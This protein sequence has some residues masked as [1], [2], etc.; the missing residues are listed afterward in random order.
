MRGPIVNTDIRLKT[1]FLDNSKII[2]LQRRK[3]ADAILSLL[4]FW[5]YVAENKPSGELCGMDS[6]DIDIA[7]GNHAT[8]MHDA[9]LELGFIEKT[10]NGYRVHDWKENQPWAANSETRSK[11]AS[12]AAAERWK[13]QR[14]P[15][16]RIDA[17][18]ML[19]AYEP[20]AEGNAPFLSF[21]P[22]SLPDQLTTSSGYISLV[23]SKI[24]SEAWVAWE[25]HRKEKKQKLT[26]STAEAQ[27]KKFSKLR[28]EIA[29]QMILQSI[30]MGWTGLF[31]LK[32]KGNQA[33]Q[34]QQEFTP[35]YFRP[36][37]DPRKPL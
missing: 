18:R 20:H 16:V 22:L 1:G 8:G 3:G 6:E 24:F 32:G 5:F 35:S 9:L 15:T 37:P 21:P 11:A 14:K 28:P 27:L 17:P 30:D 10:K 12:K 7:C 34:Q 26:P 29:A 23:T 13:P 31:E 33:P 4:R 19:C 36:A 2:K 25:T